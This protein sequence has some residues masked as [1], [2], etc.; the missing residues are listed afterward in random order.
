MTAVRRKKDCGEAI[1]SANKGVIFHT[2]DLQHNQKT[3][4]A[5]L[6]R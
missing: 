2:T 6:G 1:Q 4:L 5:A 3:K